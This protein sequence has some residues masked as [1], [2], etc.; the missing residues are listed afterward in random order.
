MLI[1]NEEDRIS[2]YDLFE[3]DL[4]KFNENRIM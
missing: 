3:C 4:V 2:W 1:I